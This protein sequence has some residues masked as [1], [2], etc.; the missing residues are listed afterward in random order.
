VVP[1]IKVA[2]VQALPVI[3]ALNRAERSPAIS[4]TK[5]HRGWGWIRKRASGRFQ[6]SYI[7]PDNVRH[8]APT[9]FD[10]KIDAEEWLTAERREVQNA[11]A[12][13]RSAVVN[14]GSAGLQWMSPLQRA[15]AGCESL[16]SAVTLNEYATEWIRQR[17]VKPRTRIHYTRIWETTSHRT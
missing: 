14:D 4:G 15:A 13:V 16:Q 10:R 12:A 3:P 9:T 1:Q 17:T 6:A 2:A 8:Y 11:E 7:G 5:N